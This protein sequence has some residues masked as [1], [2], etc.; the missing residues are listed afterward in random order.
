MTYERFLK[1]ILSLQKENKTTKTLYDNGVDLMDFVDPYHTIIN[2]LI[3]EIYGEEGYEW[4]SWYC[5]ENEFGQKDWSSEPLYKEN[6]D[7]TTEKI[8][9]KGE[10]RFGAYDVLGEPICYSHKSLWEY[11]ETNQKI[12]K[13]HI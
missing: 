11:L 1:I 6:E 10:V 4:F 5:Y 9:D 7:G 3:K 12:K 8:R 2:E 13:Q